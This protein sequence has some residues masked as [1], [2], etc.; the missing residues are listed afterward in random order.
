MHKA[1]CGPDTMRCNLGLFD[2]IGDF[3]DAV[4]EAA[5]LAQLDNYNLYWVEEPLSPTEQFIQELMKQVS[6]SIGFDFQSLLPQSLQPIAQ[7]MEQQASLLQ[8]F[9]DPKGYYAFCLNCEVQ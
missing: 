5:K 9:N 4:A 8:S 6:V 3:D 1:A 7:Q 2:Q